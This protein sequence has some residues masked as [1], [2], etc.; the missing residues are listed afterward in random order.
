MPAF[1]RRFVRPSTA[2]STTFV[3]DLARAVATEFECRAGAR[4]VALGGGLALAYRVADGGLPLRRVVLAEGDSHVLPEAVTVALRAMD[5]AGQCLVV[6]PRAWW[7]RLGDWLMG[8]PAEA[9]DSGR[10]G[11]E[12]AG[13]SGV[14]EAT[15]GAA[16]LVRSGGAAAR[17]AQPR[18]AAS[19]AA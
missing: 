17:Y 19:R 10:C 9:R 11:L 15:A 12:V 16:Y 3:V 1:R 13:A 4:I 2:A 14:G 7:A 5:E 8:V 6:A 18:G